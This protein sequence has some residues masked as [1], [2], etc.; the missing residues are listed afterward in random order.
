MIFRQFS[1]AFISLFRRIPGLPSGDLYGPLLPLGVLVITKVTVH[2]S[3]T[4]GRD[5]GVGFCFIGDRVNHPSPLVNGTQ[6]VIRRDPTVH[7]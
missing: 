1:R 6:I 3:N 4:T 2:P 7:G 5:T